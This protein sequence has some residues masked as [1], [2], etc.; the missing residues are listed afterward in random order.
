[1]RRRM[2]KVAEVTRGTEMEGREREGGKGMGAPR[3]G[4]I[5]FYYAV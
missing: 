3:V 5:M 4:F 2:G 1:M